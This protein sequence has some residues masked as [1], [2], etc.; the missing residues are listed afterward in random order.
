MKAYE[1]V[2]SDGS[3]KGELGIEDFPNNQININQ[4]PEIELHTVVYEK[5]HIRPT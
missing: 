3:K 2:M 5:K 1:V 4:L